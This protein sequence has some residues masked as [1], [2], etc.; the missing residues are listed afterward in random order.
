MYDDLHVNIKGFAVEFPLKFLEKENL[1][2]K[3]TDKEYLIKTIAF[4]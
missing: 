1:K 2:F 3:S 4:T